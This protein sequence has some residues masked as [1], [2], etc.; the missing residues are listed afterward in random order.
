MRSVGKHKL[1]EGISHL[2]WDHWGDPTPF[3]S[4]EIVLGADSKRAL[5]NAYPTNPDSLI[6][7]LPLDRKAVFVDFT[8]S[9]VISPIATFDRAIDFDGA[10][11]ALG[12]A[13]TPKSS[14]HLG[15]NTRL[16]YSYSSYAVSL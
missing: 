13:S 3:T 12:N 15:A 4:A 16:S 14:W 9:D 7:S 5:E 11:L 10:L 6:Q 8:G 1:S 2:H